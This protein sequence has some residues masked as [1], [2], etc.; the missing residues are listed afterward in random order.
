MYGQWVWFI[1]IRFFKCNS[2]AYTSKT[3]IKIAKYLSH[4]RD[5]WLKNKAV[6]WIIFRNYVSIV[7]VGICT[8]AEFKPMI[9][10]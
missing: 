8:Y 3:T 10:Y 1:L 9:I 6:T 2:I 5:D 7:I 4:M